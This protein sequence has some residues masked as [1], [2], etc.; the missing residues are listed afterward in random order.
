MKWSSFPTCCII[1]FH[2]Y[3]FPNKF[4]RL[5]IGMHFWYISLSC[6]DCI[7]HMVI[8][9]I[10]LVATTIQHCVWFFWK[11]VF[12]RAT[13]FWIMLLFILSTRLQMNLH[14]YDI[15]MKYL[16]IISINTKYN[17]HLSLPVYLLVSYRI[18]L[19]FLKFEKYIR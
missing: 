16:L 3:Y 5:N 7:V 2:Q 8:L 9:Y 10:Y 14:F 19:E 13:K 6:R 17:S 11:I 18:V 15:K 12:F 4:K 1:L